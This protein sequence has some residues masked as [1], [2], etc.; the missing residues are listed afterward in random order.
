MILPGRVAVPACT[1]QTNVSSSSC[2]GTQTV[3]G[4]CV[5]TSPMD[6]GLMD[7]HIYLVDTYI[8]NT[9][10]VVGWWLDVDLRHPNHHQ[11]RCF[12]V[13]CNVFLGVQYAP[14]NIQHIR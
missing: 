3:R 13:I 8:H 1:T 6:D 5:V 9:S 7:A 11:L 14:D 4:G 2:I 10:R 12:G